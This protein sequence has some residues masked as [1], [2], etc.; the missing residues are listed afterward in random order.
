MAHPANMKSPRRR[1]SLLWTFVGAFLAVILGAGI[2]QAIVIVAI[3]EPLARRASLDQSTLA[4]RSAARSIETLGDAGE[5]DIRRILGDANREAA[6]GLLVF[7]GTDGRILTARSLPGRIHRRLER[8]FAA[9]GDSLPTRERT[10]RRGSRSGGDE[11][12]ASSMSPPRRPDAGTAPG[13]GSRPPRRSPEPGDHGPSLVVSAR[14]PVEPVSGIRGEILVLSPELRLP[15]PVMHATRRALLFLP[16]ALILSA[17]AGTLLFRHLLKRLRK[18]EALAARVAD[19]DLDARVEETGSDEIGRLGLQ[20]NAMTGSL[21]AA[22]RQVEAAETQRRRL[23]AD[24][25]HELGTPLTSIRGYAE[26]LLDPAV[27]V[28]E[29]ERRAFLANVLGEAERMN[30]LVRD[31][32]DLARLESGAGKAVMERL[33]WSALCRNTIDRLRARFIAADITIEWAGPDTPAWIHADGRRME[34]VLDNLLGNALRYVPAGG[35]V[36]LSLAAGTDLHRLKVADDGPG[37]PDSDRPHVFDRFY[38]A[39]PARAEGGTGLGLAIVREIVTGHGGRIAVAAASP[40][41]SVFE[42]ELPAVA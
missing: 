21:A 39:D 20:L 23:L 26:T 28:S 41:G 36:T 25:S 29:E 40:R 7:R 14:V 9:T 12:E 10:G 42:V 37:I 19:G 22:R 6:P 32:L 34:Q 18:L 11:P 30:L 33:D 13:A 1:G 2:L 38:R 31:L 27:P 35:T 8:L 3:V 5:P 24:I 16:V 15:F 17:I 4:A